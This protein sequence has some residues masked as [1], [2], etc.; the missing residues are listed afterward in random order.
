MSRLGSPSSP[1]NSVLNSSHVDRTLLPPADPYFPWS[2]MK[3][4]QGSD[5]AKGQATTKGGSVDMVPIDEDEQYTLTGYGEIP[6]SRDDFLPGP[7]SVA[8]GSSRDED[9]GPEDQLED[10]TRPET[11]ESESAGFLIFPDYFS[12]VESIQGL[13]KSLFRAP[14]VGDDGKSKPKSAP[15]V[16]KGPKHFKHPAPPSYSSAYRDPGVGELYRGQIPSRVR[17]V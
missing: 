2:L 9:I 14:E 6:L 13:V 5:G 15:L 10:D 16:P 4:P 1:Y 7:L 3:K 11:P 17:F 8:M 12:F